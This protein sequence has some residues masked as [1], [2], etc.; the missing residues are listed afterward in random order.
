ME[1]TRSFA[2]VRAGAVAVPSRR[3][4]A[5]APP[6]GDPHDLQAHARREMPPHGGNT[7]YRPAAAIS[8]H[9]T[10]ELPFSAVELT[11]A[12]PKLLTPRP[13]A[14][15]SHTNTNTNTTPT[16]TPTPFSPL[17]TPLPTPR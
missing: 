5:L 6:T 8:I 9:C 15:H 16:P 14:S 17:R 4:D 2:L 13:L 11:P 7:H 10:S 12:V 3:Q 1:L